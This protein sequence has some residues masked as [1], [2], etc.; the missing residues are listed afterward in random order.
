MIKGTP[1]T[2]NLS[3]G[4][5]FGKLDS[6]TSRNAWN[7]AALKVGNDF[8]TTAGKSFAETLVQQLKA[9]GQTQKLP[10]LQ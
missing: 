4:G 5:L 6:G 9:E 8:A 1:S 10:Q 3:E 7:D 2:T